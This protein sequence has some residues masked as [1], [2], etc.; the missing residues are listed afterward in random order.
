MAKQKHWEVPTTF[1]VHGGRG[2]EAHH[3]VEGLVE[4]LLKEAD[5]SG[6]LVNVTVHRPRQLRGPADTCARCKTT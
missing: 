6:G 4:R 3:L 1:K 2:E 5:E